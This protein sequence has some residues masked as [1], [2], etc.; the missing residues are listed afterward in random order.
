MCPSCVWYTGQADVT[1]ASLRSFLACCSRIRVGNGHRSRWR[2]SHIIVAVL[3]HNWLSGESNQRP[4]HAQWA[5]RGSVRFP[6]RRCLALGSK[7]TMEK[8]AS[9]ETTRVGT[10]TTAAECVFNQ[11]VMTAGAASTRTTSRVDAPRVTRGICHRGTQLCR[12]SLCA[13]LNCVYRTSPTG[14]IGTGIMGKSMCGH[15]LKGPGLLTRHR[16]A[17]P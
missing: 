13:S 3:H 7:F 14:W 10:V 12:S 8:F 16:L 15:I 2:L 6:M 4:H 5:A 17:L 11:A 9:P 1:T